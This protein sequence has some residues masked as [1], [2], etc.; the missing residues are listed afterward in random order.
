MAVVIDKFLFLKE[1]Q[2]FIIFFLFPHWKLRV[3]TTAF[4]SLFGTS[5]NRIE[6]YLESTKS[7]VEHPISVFSVNFKTVF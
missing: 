4:E 6:Q 1:I 3:E 7:G 2:E 5:G